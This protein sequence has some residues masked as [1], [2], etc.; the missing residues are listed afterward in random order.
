MLSRNFHM[1]CENVFI[2]DSN[3]AS[4]ISFLLQNNITHILICAIELHPQH[5]NNFTYKHCP[6]I[7][8]PLFNIKRFFKECIIFIEEVIQ[9]NGNILIHCKLGRSR[10]VTIV[11][12]YL[13]KSHKL[14]LQASLNIL[15]K[16][17]PLASP[18]EGFLIQL[19]EFEKSLNKKKKS[20]A[21]ACKLF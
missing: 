7:D 9:Q 8:S 18:N 10:S 17:H 6:I 14:S 3:G 13:I 1:I 4:N 16:C 12:S 21:C 20:G 2:S 5:P 19:Q 11:L 15:Q